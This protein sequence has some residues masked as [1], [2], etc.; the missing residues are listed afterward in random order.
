MASTANFGLPINP[1]GRPSGPSGGSFGQPSGV[2]IGPPQGG[3]GA[4]GASHPGNTYQSTVNPRSQVRFQV[5][6]QVT[7]A[8]NPVYPLSDEI[9]RKDFLMVLHDKKNKDNRKYYYRG[10]AVIGLKQVNEA[11]HE[12][13][14]QRYNPDNLSGMAAIVFGALTSHEENS[15]NWNVNLVA[16]AIQPLGVYNNRG[17]H[18]AQEAFQYTRAATTS[19]IIGVNISNYCFMRDIFGVDLRVGDTMELHCVENDDGFIEFV[20]IIREH[21]YSVNAKVQEKINKGET[22]CFKLGKVWATPLHGP[23][24]REETN[25]V[26][27]KEIEENHMN[28]FKSGTNNVMQI[29]RNIEVE[30]SPSFLCQQGRPQ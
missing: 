13:H 8:V 5:Q 19:E 1:T 2:T 7:I 11:L 20:P 27:H 25:I 28:M 10:T 3:F 15:Y 23:F 6:P 17:T 22:Y 24:N 26:G 14:V 16:R 9:R 21:D 12:I 18:N 4:V 30:L 29:Y